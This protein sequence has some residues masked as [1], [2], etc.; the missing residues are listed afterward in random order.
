MN[1]IHFLCASTA[2]FQRK[3]RMNSALV[4]RLTHRVRVKPYDAYVDDNSN[5]Y[6]FVLYICIC[7]YFIALRGSQC[8]FMLFIISYSSFI[9]GAG[10]IYH[11]GY[12]IFYKLI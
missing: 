4:T 1:V 10:N 3:V 6:Q 2:C 5:F 7:I 8:L 9:F 12:I 11:V